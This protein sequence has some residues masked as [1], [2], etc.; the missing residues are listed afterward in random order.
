V[1]GQDTNFRVITLAVPI[2][3]GLEVPPSPPPTITLD[4]TPAVHG[5]VTMVLGAQ[6]WDNGHAGGAA[7]YR[8]GCL[9]S[10][11]SGAGAHRSSDQWAVRHGARTILSSGNLVRLPPSS[12][13]LDDGPFC[14]ADNA[15]VF[16]CAP[17]RNP[18]TLVTPIVRWPA[19]E[20]I[21]ELRTIKG[22]AGKNM[23]VVGGATLVAS[24]LNE[25]LIDYDKR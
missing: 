15:R 6:N 12:R 16:T 23:Y 21:S 14:G 24:L 13:R 8:H 2:S 19:L 17:Y 11:K 22:Q 9:E 5:V 1:T 10:D 18:V 3:A 7:A 4:F 25:D 20:S